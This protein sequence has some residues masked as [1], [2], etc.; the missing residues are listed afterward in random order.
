MRNFYR[1]VIILCAAILLGAVLL[2]AI[3]ET[4]RPRRA[5]TAC[6]R[7]RDPGLA[8]VRDLPASPGGPHAGFSPY[9]REPY[10]VPQQGRQANPAAGNQPYAGLL[11][12]A[13]P[14]R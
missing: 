13:C 12:L 9:R 3:P 4:S 10:V 7:G 2:T 8:H 6:G 5:P 14:P 1:N 11:A